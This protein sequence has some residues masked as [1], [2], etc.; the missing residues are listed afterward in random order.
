[1][2]NVYRPGWRSQPWIVW[3][4]AFAFVGAYGLFAVQPESVQNQLIYTFAVIPAR[5]DAGDRDH[6]TTWYEALLP[7]VGHVFLHGGWV[8]VGVNTLVFLQGAP[9]VAWRMGALRFVL[10]F[11]LSAI[12]SA[13]GFILLNLHGATPAV[14][15]SGAICGVFAAY[16]LSVRNSWAEALADPQVR[17][18]AIMFLVINVGL[19]GVAS[20]SGILPIAWQAHLGGFLAGGLAYLAFG[21]KPFVGPWSQVKARSV[22]DDGPRLGGP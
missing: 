16:F 21:P 6:F 17:N 19:A 5:F 10:L 3:L 12:G 8:H 11:L 4:L 7:F 14:G 22:Q 1:V 15:A 13:A 9:F 20:A 18:A 2:S